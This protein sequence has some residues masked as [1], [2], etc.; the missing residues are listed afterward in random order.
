MEAWSK[1]VVQ[2]DAIIMQSA[3]GCAKDMGPIAKILKK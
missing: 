1:S 2:K 3:K